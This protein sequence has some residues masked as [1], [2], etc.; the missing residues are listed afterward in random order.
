MM[1]KPLTTAEFISRAKQVHGDKY[2]YSNTVYVLSKYK[3]TIICKKHGQFKQ[4]PDAHLVGDVDC[5]P[6]NLNELH[7]HH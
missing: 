3:I 5:A 1:R 4:R 7:Y 6:E 2:D